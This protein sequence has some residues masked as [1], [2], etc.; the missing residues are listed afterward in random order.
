MA[1]EWQ[2]WV[3]IC[4]FYVPTLARNW[5]T[6][7]VYV[8]NFL[9]IIKILQL[10]FVKG[11]FLRS[12]VDTTISL[13]E[14]M[15]E[16]KLLVYFSLPSFEVILVLYTLNMSELFYCKSVFQLTLG[17]QK[18]LNQLMK[19]HSFTNDR[20]KLSPINDISHC[21]SLTQPLIDLYL[22][23]YLCIPLLSITKYG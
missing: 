1:Q 13:F 19:D 14:W 11:Y 20:N 23:N 16:T 2:N 17:P 3:E 10:F 6:T 18:Q 15:T 12:W 7:F 8:W 5:S 4:K 9:K 22:W 21:D